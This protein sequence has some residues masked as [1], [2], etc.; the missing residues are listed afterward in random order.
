MGGAV[1]DVVTISKT[2]LEISIITKKE[3]FSSNSD[4]LAKL[5]SLGLPDTS[6][7]YTLMFS[8]VPI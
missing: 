8:L 3:T 7:E 5:K 2:K 1:F 4:W 6:S